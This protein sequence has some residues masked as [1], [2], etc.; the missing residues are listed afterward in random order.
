MD[1]VANNPAFILSWKPRQT[2]IVQKVQFITQLFM[3]AAYGLIKLSVIYFY[4]RIFNI[5]K[6][7]KF[8]L[9]TNAFSIFIVAW[10]V[11]YIFAVAFDC[12]TNW[13]AHWGSIAD[14]LQYC[15]GGAVIK[16]VQS[17]LYTDLITDVLILLLPMPRVS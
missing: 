10:T 8:N 4:R 16:I 5:D 12:R 3:V 6:S 13:F 11:A 15:N 1:E 9:V 17:L 2:V 14:I 7:G